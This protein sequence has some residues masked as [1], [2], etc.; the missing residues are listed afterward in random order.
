MAKPRVFVSSTYYDLKHIR[1]SLEAFIDSLGYE[2]ILFES[3]DIPFH[4]D[5]SLDI[6]CYDAVDNAHIFV[7]IVG[8]R[9]GSAATNAKAKAN[10]AVSDPDGEAKEMFDFYNSITVEE[11]RRARLKDIPIYIFVEKGVAAEYLTYRE[12]RDT[13]NIKYAHV[14]NVNIFRLVDGI[15]AEDRNNLVREFE[16]FEHIT[17]W[18]KLQWAGL[19]ADYLAKKKADATIN[20]LSLQ[21]QNLSQVVEALKSYSQEIVKKIEPDEQKSSKIIKELEDRL[22]LDLVGNNPFVRYLM[23]THQ[24]ESGVA[25]DRAAILL[26]AIGNADVLKF[27]QALTSSKQVDAGMKRF[28]A[29]AKKDH[30]ALRRKIYEF[31]ELQPLFSEPPTEETPEIPDE[32]RKMLEENKL[33]VDR[34][35]ILAAAERMAMHNATPAAPKAEKAAPVK[36]A[37]RTTKKVE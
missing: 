29:S 3:G 14:D 19:F 2:S 24:E 18:L 7:L 31:P 4:H 13:P 5:K 36:R 8:G 23:R 21:V 11:Y 30:E 10:T 28:Y 12:N 17:S 26:A 1:A 20:D 9:Y 35:A 22:V 16:R 25:L 37:R 33:L 32:V 27:V 6:S 34:A 15:Y